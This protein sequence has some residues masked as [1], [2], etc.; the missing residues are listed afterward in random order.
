[1]T[2]VTPVIQSAGPY[3]P[4]SLFEPLHRER[5]PTA[6]NAMLHHTRMQLPAARKKAQGRLGGIQN[7][8]VSQARGY[9]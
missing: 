1:M 6:T 7:R 9:R 8:T 2:L 5:A 4:Y 3:G